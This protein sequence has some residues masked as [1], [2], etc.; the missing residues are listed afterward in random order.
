VASIDR[1]A[2][3]RFKRVVSAREITEAFTPSEDEIVWARS[4]TTPD[5]HLLA[6]VVLLKCYQRLGYFPKLVD[7]P[8]VVVACMR[9]TPGAAE[10][11]VAGHE[12]ERTLWRHR[13]FVRTRMGVVYEPARV[14]AVA[15]RAIRSAA[16][17]K[18]NPA[19]LINVALEELVRQ[20]CELP[21]Y[22]TLDAITTSIRMEVNSGFFSMVTGR[23]PMADRA[24]LA[25]LFLGDPVARRSEFDRLRTVLPSPVENDV[26]RRTAAPARPQR[27]AFDDHRIGRP[28]I[29]V[30][31]VAIQRLTRGHV[32]DV[33]N[34][35]SPPGCGIR[36]RNGSR[37]S[38]S[39]LTAINNSATRPSRRSA[40]ADGGAPRRTN[41]S[42]APTGVAA[43]R[44]A[45]RAATVTR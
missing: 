33:R 30:D 44:R 27:H 5:G 40:R 41:E 32:P 35:R 22:T 29:K 43:A 10:S 21:G 11:V 3:P 31:W 7:V 12:S 25:R 36:N 19:D 2:Y 24:R 23:I 13:E 42:S 28:L 20:S 34:N 45:R 38:A 37:E 4:K 39:G 9:S 1:T 8:D 16:L 18:D 14:R 26:D 6:L 15:E 17:T